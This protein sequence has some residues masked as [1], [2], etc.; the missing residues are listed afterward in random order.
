M[1]KRIDFNWF[2]SQE[3]GE[4][5]EQYIAGINCLKIEEHLPFG[6]GDR[7]FYDIYLEDRTILRTFNPN[8]VVIT[9]EN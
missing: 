4:H 8:F 9:K 2:F 3:A 1:I 6:E 7:V 5:C